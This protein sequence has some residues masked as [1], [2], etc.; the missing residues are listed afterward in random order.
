MNVAYIPDAACALGG[1]LVWQTSREE[2]MLAGCCRRENGGNATWLS[3][4]NTELTSSSSA[5]ENVIES[6]RR[7]P[8]ALKH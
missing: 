3:V 1:E 8:N 5:K 4:A 7:R 2:L 6:A